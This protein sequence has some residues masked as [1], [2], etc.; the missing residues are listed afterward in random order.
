[1]AGEMADGMINTSPDKKVIQAFQEAGGEGKP[2]LG[3]ITLCYAG[4]EQEALDTAFKWWPTTIVPSALHS[5][6][7]TPDHFEQAVKLVRK[8]DIAGKLPLGPDTDKL[9]ESIQKYIEAGFTHLYF[10]QVGPDQEGFLRYFQQ[11][12]MPKL[13]DKA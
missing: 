12:V 10:H 4:T 7:P 5:D 2:V 6:L 8:E 11:Q 9:M 13:K 1:M 3:Q